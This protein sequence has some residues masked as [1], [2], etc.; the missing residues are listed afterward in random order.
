MIDQ[1]ESRVLLA[2]RSVQQYL[3]P[4][5]PPILAG[6]D[7]ACRCEPAELIGGDYYDFIPMPLGVHIGAMEI[8]EEIPLTDGDLLVLY[9]DG[10]VERLSRENEIFGTARFVECLRVQ[11]HQTAAEIVDGVFQ[12]VRDFSGGIVHAVG[13]MDSVSIRLGKGQTVLA[14]GSDSRRIAS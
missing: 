6:Y 11:R 2:A 8:S 13:V 1:V 10:L 3:L 5:A 4:D 9:T 12:E 14:P 7:I